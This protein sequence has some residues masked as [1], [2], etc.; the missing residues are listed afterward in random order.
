MKLIPL[1]GLLGKGKFAIVDDCDFER[2]S[3]HYYYIGQGVGRESMT[4]IMTNVRTEEIQNY[5]SGGRRWRRTYLH[6]LIIG[7]KKGMNVKQLNGDKLDFRRENL[8]HV[9]HAKVLWGSKK[10]K[11]HGNG[12]P[13]SKYKG[14]RQM[15]A[16]RKKRWIAQIQCNKKRYWLGYFYTEEDAAHA[17]DTKAE[18][19]FGEYARFNFPVEA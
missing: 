4:G 19:L 8:R 7:Y 10:R 1:H 16:W 14:V 18:E 2:L 11:R 5:P 12:V 13:T 3:K 9:E 15:E 6:D 17:Y